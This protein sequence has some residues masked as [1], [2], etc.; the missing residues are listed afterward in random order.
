[1]KVSEI[2]ELL[3]RD[4]LAIGTQMTILKQAGLSKP[5]TL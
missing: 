4:D 2:V 3:R 1:M 5:N